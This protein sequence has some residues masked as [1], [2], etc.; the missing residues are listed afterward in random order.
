MLNHLLLTGCHR[1]DVFLSS[2]TSMYT[3]LHGMFTP[4][5]STAK[6]SLPRVEKKKT[7]LLYVKEVKDKNLYTSKTFQYMKNVLNT[8]VSK[9]WA[10]KRNGL[11]SLTFLS[12]K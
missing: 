1:A 10:I 2:V 11:V 7:S 4:R 5:S 9:I 3:K 6:R 8:D 12:F